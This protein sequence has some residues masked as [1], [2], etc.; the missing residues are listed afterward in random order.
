M[1]C[2]QPESPSIFRNVQHHGKTF[3]TLN[4]MREQRTLCDVTVRV[5]SRDILGIYVLD[6]RFLHLFI[7]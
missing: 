4:E 1:A 6:Y 7:W 5:G 3:E 2:S